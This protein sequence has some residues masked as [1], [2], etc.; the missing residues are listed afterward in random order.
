MCSEIERWKREVV[1]KILVFCN[2]HEIR[3]TYSAVGDLIGII[4]RAV[5]SRYLGEYS[6]WT[7]WIVNKNSALPTQNFPEILYHTNLRNE[8]EVID[9]ADLLSNSLRRSNFILPPRPQDRPPDTG[10]YQ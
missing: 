1:N 7:S 5:G 4:P 10:L 3:V 2:E 9:N 8:N 6:P